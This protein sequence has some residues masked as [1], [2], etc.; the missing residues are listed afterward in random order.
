MEKFDKYLEK[1]GITTRVL[2]DRVRFLY[3]IASKMCPEEIEQL[4]IE[5]SI[6]KDN[7]RAYGSLWFFSK[8]FMLEAHNFEMEYDI[9]IMAI[10]VIRVELKLNHYNLKEAGE[11]SRLSV[12]INFLLGDIIGELKAANENCDVLRD[13]AFKYIMP[14]LNRLT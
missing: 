7:T 9:D 13:I 10:K 8:G 2:S 11:K 3:D 1:V 4:F 12:Y 5:D 14:K 6:K